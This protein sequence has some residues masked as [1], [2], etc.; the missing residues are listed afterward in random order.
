MMKILLEILILLTY[1]LVSLHFNSEKLV[2]H[3]YEDNLLVVLLLISVNLTMH[4]LMLYKEKLDVKHCCNF[5]KITYY[6][7]QTFLEYNYILI[8]TYHNDPVYLD[9]CKYRIRLL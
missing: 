7:R 4:I 5:F 6:Q 3:Q 1:C 8:Q 9:P 2:I